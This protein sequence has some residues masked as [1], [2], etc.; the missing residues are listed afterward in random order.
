MSQDR[1]IA[2]RSVMRPRSAASKLVCPVP[3]NTPGQSVR[4]SKVVWPFS[5]AA[6]ADRTL[7]VDAGAYAA[8]VARNSSGEPRSSSSSA[9][10]ASALMP[11]V[12]AA[13][14]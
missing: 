7:N 5:T 13:G 3:S 14:S 1:T 8:W 2:V 4:A 6:A 12:N 9:A 11:S 10:Y